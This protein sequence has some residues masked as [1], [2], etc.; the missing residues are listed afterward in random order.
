ML[1]KNYALTMIGVAIR[2]LCK[3]TVVTLLQYLNQF[4]E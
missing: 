4:E 1:K 3:I 2:L